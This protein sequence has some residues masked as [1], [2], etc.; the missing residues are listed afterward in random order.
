MRK[1]LKNDDFLLKIMIAPSLI[2]LLGV[3]VPFVR[4]VWTSLTNSKLYSSTS[5]SFIWF[6]N[7][8]SMLTSSIFWQGLKVLTIFVVAVLLIQ[9]ILGLIVAHLLNVKTKFTKISRSVLVVPLLIPPV[10]ASLLWKTLMWPTDGVL[11][12]F[13]SLVNLGPY[14]W[15]TS[16]TTA[17][18][19]T[20]I[21]DTW[22]YLPFVTV[23]ILSGLQSV[24][25]EQI[26]AAKLDGAN[27]W[28]IF[29]HVSL[30]WLVPYIF[31]AGLF[32]G[33]DAIKTFDVIYSTTRGGPI[34]STRVLH[35]QAYEEGFRWASAGSAMAIVLFLWFIVLLFSN[36]L[37][38]LSRF[39]EFRN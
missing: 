19:S 26:E 1:Q 13:L 31:I 29:K 23:I 12:W 17:L 15:L 4:G 38:K 3:L 30:P 32:R 21:I 11:N 8:R 28:Q 27:S 39:R 5:S 24:S 18:V 35:I 25:H 14:Q 22:I 9:F 7:Y 37:I 20:I 10:V 33:A 36:I 2:L 34:D 16:P 6:E